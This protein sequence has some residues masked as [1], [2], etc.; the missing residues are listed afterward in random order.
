[1]AVSYTNESLEEAAL[2][3]LE[4]WIRLAYPEAYTNNPKSSYSHDYVTDLYLSVVKQGNAIHDADIQ[5]GLGVLFNLSY[6]HAKAADCFR[7]ALQLRPQ[8][9]KHIL[10]LSNHIGISLVLYRIINF[11]TSWELRWPTVV[12]VKKPFMPITKR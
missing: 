12:V 7:M 5:V 11:G 3:A 10:L 2:Y 9:K 6:D 1:L 8:V 4:R